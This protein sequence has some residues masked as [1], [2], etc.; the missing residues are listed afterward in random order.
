MRIDGDLFAWLLVLGILN[1]MARDLSPIYYSNGFEWYTNR[2]VGFFVSPRIPNCKSAAHP[3]IH[4]NPGKKHRGQTVQKKQQE[5]PG[6]D[7]GRIWGFEILQA[8]TPKALLWPHRKPPRYRFHWPLF[9]HR[10][11]RRDLS[12]HK[13]LKDSGDPNYQNDL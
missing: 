2:D 7:L 11:A 10:F 8:S 6:K 13:T 4:Q 1:R 9:C 3:R 5:R 12:H